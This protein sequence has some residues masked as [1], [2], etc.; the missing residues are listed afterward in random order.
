[1]ETS[2][3]H[4]AD[5]DNSVNRD[6]GIILAVL[7][8][9]H[10]VELPATGYSMF[11]T[12]RPGDKVIVRPLTKGELPKP[13]SVVVY[14]ENS[15]FVMHRLVEIIGCDSG[16]VQFITRG[17]S[18]SEPDKPWPQQK[19]LGVANCYKRGNR[20]YPVK[21]FV[22]GIW[23][24]KFNRRLLWLYNWFMWFWNKVKG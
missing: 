14:K 9:G 24:Y 12:L 3:L 6:I 15:G 16:Y 1:V 7:E 21:T 11:P 20:E 19:L 2:P 8:S 13:G 5:S 17:D 4:S 18:M 23:R 22:P 10:S